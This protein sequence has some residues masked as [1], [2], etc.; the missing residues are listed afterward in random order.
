MGAI[1]GRDRIRVYSR[2][3]AVSELS[4]QAASLGSH[5]VI[6]TPIHMRVDLSSDRLAQLRRFVCAA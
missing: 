1:P 2:P 3:L 5:D 4:R 6:L